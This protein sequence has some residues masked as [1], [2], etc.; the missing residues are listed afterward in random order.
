MRPLGALAEVSHMSTIAPAVTAA[1]RSPRQSLAGDHLGMD[2]PALRDS[3]LK[4]LE[5][6]LAEL[7]GHVDS[8]WE[9]YVSLALALRDRLVERWIRTQD[10]Y[11]DQDPKRVYYL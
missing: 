5:F 10:S 7:P 3:F 9:P 4:H 2:A 1:S 6:T 11:Y 8:E